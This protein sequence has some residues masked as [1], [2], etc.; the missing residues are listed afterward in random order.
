MSKSL[1][2]SEKW[3]RRGLWLVAFIFAGFLI[4]L[5]GLLISDLPRVER[6]YDIQDFVDAEEAAPFRAQ[7]DVEDAEIEA[8]HALRRQA[9]F[10]LNGASELNQS[11]RESFEN[12]VSTREA[13]DRADYDQE[14]IERTQQLDK[15]VGLE[16]AARKKVRELR[17]EI[18]DAEERRSEAYASLSKLEERASERYT[19][20]YDRSMLRVFVYRLALTIPLLVLAGWLFVRKRQS[21]W[22]PFVWGF[23]IFAVF[24]FFFELVPYLPHFGGYVRAIVGVVATILVGRYT[25]ISLNRYLERQ[26]EIEAQPDELRRKELSYD[27]ALSRL[28]KGVCP[29]CERSV[30]L[31]DGVTD[32]CPHCGICIYD[33]CAQC[34]SRKNAFSKFCFQCGT[35]EPSNVERAD[36][37]ATGPA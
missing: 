36:A 25:I 35:P 27:L 37:H 18:E 13:T 6:S 28:D 2:R 29:S 16:N 7:M 11:A 30:D 15:L 5:G 3:F 22:W 21:K 31:K 33:Q 19:A 34:D 17:K 23:I 10:E 8:L 20:A 14:L 32:F 1:R 9:D 24:V 12:W 4:T 26:R